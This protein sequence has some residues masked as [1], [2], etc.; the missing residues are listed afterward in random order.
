MNGCF[1]LPL[2]AYVLWIGNRSVIPH[3]KKKKAEV[4]TE[5]AFDFRMTFPFAAYQY[6]HCHLSGH[7]AG[8][9]KLAHLNDVNKEL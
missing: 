3:L 6:R 5:S 8:Q 7:M 9:L 1:N 2:S 4:V